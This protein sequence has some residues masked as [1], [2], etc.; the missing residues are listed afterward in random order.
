MREII[1]PVA[2]EDRRIAKLAAIAIGLTLAE[3]ALPSPIP[4]I[5]PG[6]ANIVILLVL[7][8]HGFKAAVQVSVIRLL[9]GSLLLGSFLSPGFW[10]SASGTIASLMMLSIIQYLPEKIFGPV[11]LSILTALAHIGGQL[12]L[13]W[14]WLLPS[15]GILALLPFFALAALAFG[16]TNGLIV[17]WLIAEKTD[18]G[19]QSAHG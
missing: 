8:Q 15:A 17:A 13:A 2:A 19:A 4:G 5:K 9:A 11:S 1:L 12:A 16:A 7:L 14:A 6:L 18:M 3:A 10:L